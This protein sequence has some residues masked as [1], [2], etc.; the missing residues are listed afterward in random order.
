MNYNN[1]LIRTIYS[2]GLSSLTL[3][4]YKT[5]LSLSF[6]PMQLSNYKKEN[7]IYISTTISDESVATILSFCQA[8][9]TGKQTTSMKYTI[10][11]NN[12]TTLTFECEPNRDRQLQAYLTI[13]KNRQSTPFMFEIRPCKINENGREHIEFVQTGLI[14][15]SKALEAYLTGIAAE[16]S[17]YGNNYYN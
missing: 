16:R 14:V 9:L 1:Y 6:S 15:F 10:D 2:T 5:N 12:Q 7:K 13:E 17:D 4:F 8:I 3:S 11:C